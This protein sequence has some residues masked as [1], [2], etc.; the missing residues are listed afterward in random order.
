MIF[1]TIA[2][3]IHTVITSTVTTTITT[4]SNTS[5]SSPPSSPS[6]SPS[7]P[8]SSPS[9][10]PP[11]SP[12][13]HRT[14]HHSHYDHHQCYI[15]QHHLHHHRQQHV[16]L[17]TT[18]VVIPVS[19]ADAWPTRASQAWIQDPAPGLR[20][21]RSLLR[22][23]VAW[24]SHQVSLTHSSVFTAPLRWLVFCLPSCLFVPVGGENPGP[25][26]P[27]HRQKLFN[28]DF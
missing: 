10:S 22:P 2:I 13:Y 6:S 5:P 24:S 15:H 25:R 16:T 27:Y 1:I 19:P 18:V 23:S 3:T 8:P 14:R 11:S 21:Q 9:S 7:T 4:V 26:T 17:I 20:P 12:W 28:R